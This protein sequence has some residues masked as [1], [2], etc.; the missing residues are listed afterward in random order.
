MDKNFTFR[1]FPIRQQVQQ[2]SSFTSYLKDCAATF[3]IS[4]IE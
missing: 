3:G 1:S 2:D 4:A